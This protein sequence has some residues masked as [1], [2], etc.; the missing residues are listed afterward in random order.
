MK[1]IFKIFYAFGMNENQFSIEI[2]VLKI[3]DIAIHLLH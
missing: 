1:D 3:D 2:A